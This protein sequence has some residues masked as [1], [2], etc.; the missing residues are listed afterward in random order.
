MI[1]AGVSGVGTQD[2]YFARFQP[3]APTIDELSS[4]DADLVEKLVHHLGSS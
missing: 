3:L 2:G 4:E 1:V